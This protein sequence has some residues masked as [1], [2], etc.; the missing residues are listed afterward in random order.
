MGIFPGINRR[1]LLTTA[2][3]TAVVGIGPSIPRAETAAK[4]QVGSA[5][6][7]APPCLESPTRNLTSITVLRL[8]EIA[9]RNSIRQEAGLPLLSV[10]KELR[11]MKEAANLDKFRAF[12]EA[13]RTRVFAK[14]LGRVRRR[15][16]DPNW[17]PTGV[18]SGGGLCF[19]G[20]VDRQ[21]RTLYRRTPVFRSKMCAVEPGRAG[22][23]Y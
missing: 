21:L 1:R 6:A 19:A 13:N 14:M 18:L 23:S 2:A 10:P 8:R 15:C 20:H 12:A 4:S 9:E 17:T 3:A 16:G 22:Q 5:N 11:R 7:L